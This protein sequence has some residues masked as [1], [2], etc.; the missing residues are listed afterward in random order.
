MRKK[1]DVCEEFGDRTKKRWKIT[2]VITDGNQNGEI[3][4]SICV[5]HCRI[6]NPLAWDRGWL[7]EIFTCRRIRDG[8]RPNEWSLRHVLKRVFGG[9]RIR[10]EIKKHENQQI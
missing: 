6:R 8:R 2:P 7:D 10:E 3:P 9:E 4:I 5:E 1:R